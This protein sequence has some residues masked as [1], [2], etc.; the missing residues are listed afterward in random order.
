DATQRHP[1]QV[2]GV[3]RPSRI[4][5]SIAAMCESNSHFVE[6]ALRVARGRAALLPFDPGEIGTSGA[7]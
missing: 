3:T 2:M 1:T 4:D 7:P 6:K 5:R